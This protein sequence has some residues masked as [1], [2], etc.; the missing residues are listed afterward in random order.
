MTA[1]AS[2]AG[3]NIYA[4]GFTTNGE[5]NDLAI[6]K[7]DALLGTESWRQSIAGVGSANGAAL[8][9]A[10]VD[11][12]GN[13]VLAGYRSNGTD[14]DFLVIKVSSAGTLLWQADEGINDRVSTSFSSGDVYFGARAL[15]VDAAGNA[16]VT[17]QSNIGGMS[18][19]VTAKIDANGVTQWRSMANGATNFLDQAYAIV[20]DGAGNVFV[21]GDSYSGGNSDFLTVKYGPA[22]NELWRVYTEGQTGSQD[23]L[24]AL[25]VDAAGDVIVTGA[26][27]GNGDFLT[28]KYNANQVEQWRMPAAGNAGGIDDP[29]AIAVDAARNVYVTGQSFDGTNYGYL[30]VKYNAL[31][32][33]QW[34]TAE[35]SGGTSRRVYAIAVDGTGNVIV[36]GK[37]TIKYSAGGTELWRVSDF[38]AYAVAV[39]AA[40]NVFLGGEGGLTVKYSAGGAELWRATIGATGGGD[41]V[42]ALV[43]DA[44]QNVYVTSQNFI[45]GLSDFTTVKYSP[46]G[47][48]R[49]RVTTPT[50][51]NVAFSPTALALDA[52]RAVLVAGNTLSPGLP[53]AMSVVKYRQSIAAPVII[54]AAPGNGSATVSFSPPASDGG[55]P[56]S[57]YTA[58]CGVFTS[59]GSASPLLVTGLSNGTPYSCS[60]TATNAF[61][62]S[63]ASATMPVT[64][65]ASAPLALITVHSRKAHGGLGS[66]DWRVDTG[67]PIG[68]AIAVEPRAI[69]AGHVLRFRFNGTV[70]SP[71]TAVALDGGV[72]P[73]G[74]VSPPTF[75]GDTVEVILTGIPDR[76]RLTVMLTGV[77]TSTNVEVSLGFMQG[78]VN[79]SRAVNASDIS[80][81]KARIL[82]PVTVANF[83]FD[84]N[85]SGLIDQADLSNVKSRTGT[86]LP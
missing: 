11:P 86:A 55:A 79:Q 66:F 29:V 23:L 21:S 54:A 51:G 32:N 4:T 34:I 73:I 12:F 15:A 25:A 2:D 5:N 26:T 61:G 44:D 22:G 8:M 48:E 7:Y 84:L 30:T 39:D 58:T 42:N 17:G 57:A 27:F 37:P 18:D 75:S 81:V 31:G 47:I 63:P 46:G 6:V 24:R 3:G 82:Q 65:S 52:Q 78:D 83:Q 85:A 77:N 50:N 53:P 9:V 33:Q 71:G 49:W 67:L 69:G 45:N 64:P 70:T 10:A 41:I 38:Q 56:I 1:L 76:K 16:Y 20:V 62:I 60:V 19:F 68:A 36:A 35:P 74:T 80:A 72:T 43:L 13:I 28:V 14:D 59:A 40:G